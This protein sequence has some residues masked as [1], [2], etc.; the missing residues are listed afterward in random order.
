MDFLTSTMQKIALN[1]LPGSVWQMLRG[2]V[3]VTT[4]IFS[5]FFL[6]MRPRKNHY[7]GCAFAILGII[8]V[9]IS[10]VAFAEKSS[11]SES[12]TVNIFII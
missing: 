3:I 6:Q 9:G 8:I 11:S 2:G 1:F 7:F 5:R 10:N 12:D 4:A